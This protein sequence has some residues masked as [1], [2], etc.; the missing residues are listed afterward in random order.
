M[1]LRPVVNNWYGPNQFNATAHKQSCTAVL[2]PATAAVAI[3]PALLLSS[4]MCC[5]TLQVDEAMKMNTSDNVS[6]I[7]ICLTSD[8]PPK[9]VFR[10]AGVT[11]TLSTNGITR[12]GSAILDAAIDETATS[13]QL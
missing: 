4:G 9:R 2:I 10:Q 5:M 6:L 12:L 8:A 11:R 3:P 7:T 1:I 13:S